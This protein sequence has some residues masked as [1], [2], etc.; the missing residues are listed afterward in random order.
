MLN[1]KLDFMKNAFLFGF[2]FF[3]INSFA[4]SYEGISGIL[5]DTSI[6][7]TSNSESEK[8]TWIG[9]E[10]GLL[11]INK[12]NKKKT[13][14]TTSNS[15]LPSNHITRICCRKN[16]QVW[17]GTQ[18]GIMVYDNYGYIL[19]TKE[20]SKLP[21]E[22]I[23]AITEDK[24]EDLWLGTQYGGLVKLHHT[25]FKIYNKNNSFL[26]DNS[27]KSL[28]INESGNMVVNGKATETIYAS[29]KK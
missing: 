5:L 25:I 13:F 9:T 4:Q 17:I 29:L 27:I 12:K 26:N 15:N 11:R 22:Y 19:Y 24:N 2:I 16:G 1:V 7:V 10:K 28:T 8:F 18:R 14:L 20:N 21:D 6:R 23:T 3:V